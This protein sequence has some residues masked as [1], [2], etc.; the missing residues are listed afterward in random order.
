ML[1]SAYLV[2]ALMLGTPVGPA[3]TR[4]AIPV[5]DLEVCENYAKAAKEHFKAVSMLPIMDGGIGCVPASDIDKP[6][7]KPKAAEDKP[8]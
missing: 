3:E 8:A 4:V 6:A 7:E 1:Y 5:V 2:I